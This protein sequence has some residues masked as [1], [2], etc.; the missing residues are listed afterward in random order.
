MIKML[1]IKNNRIGFTLVEILVA[2]GIFGLIAVPA[3]MF[4]SYTAAN[5]IEYHKNVSASRLMETFK[6]DIKQYSFEESKG[7]TDANNAPPNTKKIYDEIKSKFSD[8]EMKI[9]LENVDEKTIRF[10]LTVTWK[11]RSGDERKETSTCV[12]VK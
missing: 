2:L 12:K 7:F 8:L 10:T 11:S 5:E 1:M 3:Y 6:N 4:F 9:V